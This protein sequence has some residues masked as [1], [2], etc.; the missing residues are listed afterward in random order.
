[1][2]CWLNWSCSERQRSAFEWRS[3]PQASDI[4]GWMAR[5]G[6]TPV[7]TG[8]IIGFSATAALTRYVSSLLYDIKPTDPLTFTAV[9]IVMIAVAV[10]AM[11]LPARRALQVDPLTAL[12]SE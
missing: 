9:L 10:V 11:T 4:T 7:L 2:E 1:M 3:A 8:V 5:V 6:G 12:C